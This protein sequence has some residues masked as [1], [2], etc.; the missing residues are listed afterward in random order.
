[1]R[2]QLK[3]YKLKV[4]ST[5]KESTRERRPYTAE[6][7]YKAMVEINPQLDALRRALDTDIE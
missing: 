7:R 3:N 2:K 4:I 5:I 6:E 1:M